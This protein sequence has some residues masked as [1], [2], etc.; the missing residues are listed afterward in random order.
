MLPQ[1][2]SL[3]H[4]DNFE[5][6]ALKKHQIQEG[7][8]DPLSLLRAGVTSPGTGA[9]P[10]QEKGRHFQ[11]PSKGTRGIHTQTPLHPYPTTYLSIVGQLGSKDCFLLSYHPLHIYC[12]LLRILGK[13]EF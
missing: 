5:L 6:K 10:A 2:M 12:S 9:L 3:A 4:I 13:L 1:I 11:Q 7:H 8:Q